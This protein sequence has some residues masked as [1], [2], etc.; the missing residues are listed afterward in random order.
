M[1]MIM[2]FA[3]NLSNFK[4]VFIELG[5]F[6]LTKFVKSKGFCNRFTQD[7]CLSVVILLY[8]SLNNKNK[9]NSLN[10]AH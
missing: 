2:G 5:A 7:I 4:S 8:P 10:T 3:L 9:R 6:R 1:K